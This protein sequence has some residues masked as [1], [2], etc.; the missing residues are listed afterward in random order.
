MK[1]MKINNLKN[2]ESKNIQQTNFTPKYSR[3]L[4]LP[5]QQLCE[6]V[7]ENSN[8]VSFQGKKITKRMLTPMIKAG[9][10]KNKIAAELGIGHRTLNIYL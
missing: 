5:S 6:D 9:K 10:S 3:A 8:S 2:F 4:E 1:I 7:V